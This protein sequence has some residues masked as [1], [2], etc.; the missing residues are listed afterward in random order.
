MWSPDLAMWSPDHDFTQPCRISL[1]PFF[2]SV[3]FFLS[4]SF[5]SLNL[6]LQV[7]PCKYTASQ[8]SATADGVASWPAHRATPMRILY[9]DFPMNGSTSGAHACCLGYMVCFWTASD[10]IRNPKMALSCLGPFGLIFRLGPR[11]TT[12]ALTSSARRPRIVSA[13]RVMVLVREGLNHSMPSPS[14]TIFFHQ[15]HN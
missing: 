3:F 8:T 13:S 1:L 4:N 12:L 10:W 6:F 9:A 14:T 15:R 2:H 11:D 7:E 5:F